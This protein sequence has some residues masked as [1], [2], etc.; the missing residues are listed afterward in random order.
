MYSRFS[1][2][3]FSFLVFCLV[4]NVAVAAEQQPPAADVKNIK[5]SLV[6]LKGNYS[7]REDLHKFIY[8]ESI[9]MDQILSKYPAASVI[10]ELIEC[11]DDTADSKSQLKKKFV[12]LGVICYEALSQLVYYE[13]TE[14]SGDTEQKW[15]GFITPVASLKQLQA[16][17]AAWKKAF[18]DKLLI[19][20]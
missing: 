20:Q 16:A 1:I 6:S 8:S 15:E 17:K 14:S 7:W 3:R 19:S 2:V 12:P 11:I 13:P 5:Q 18:D 4:S 10:P 9:K